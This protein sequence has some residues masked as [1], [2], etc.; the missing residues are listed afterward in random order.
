M[1]HSDFETGE[2]IG[3]QRRVPRPLIAV[4]AASD[5]VTPQEG[6]YHVG[7]KAS[8]AGDGIGKGTHAVPVKMHRRSAVAGEENISL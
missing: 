7:S 1:Q 3:L 4:I 2:H 5:P 6:L 8:G